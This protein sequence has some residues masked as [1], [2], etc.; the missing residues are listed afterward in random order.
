MA[1]LLRPTLVV[2]LGNPGAK[3]ENTRH[4]IGFVVLDALA[5]GW[6]IP[7]AEQK[8]F[9]GWFGEG[10]IAGT[11]VRLLKPSTYMNQSGQAIRAVVDWYKLEPTTVLVVYDDMDLGVGR[12][13]LR[14]SGSAGG[15]NGMK[16]AIAHLGTQ[17]FPRL[18]IGIGSKQQDAVS[19]VLG[20][21]APGEKL[22]IQEVT[23]WAVAA[24]ETS[25]KEGVEK[26]MNL[27]NNR[28]V[29]ADEP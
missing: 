9:H 4:N 1:E 24:I 27:Y 26:A 16:S 21:F 2:G 23:R 17:G 13:R 14:L 22:M 18:R 3:Y 11:K 12:L 6:N 29:K 5:R 19:H 20:S 7:L 10:A 15:Q 8:K 25:L 28:E